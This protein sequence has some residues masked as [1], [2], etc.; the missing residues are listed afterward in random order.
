MAED[1]T[2][3]ARAPVEAFQGS[4]SAYFDDAE[5]YM[6]KQWEP[7]IWPMIRDFDFSVTLDFAAGHGRNSTR[8]AKL[9]RQLYIVDANADA[10]NFLRKRFADYDARQCSI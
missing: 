5:A 6:G 3:I 2:A 9:A 4:A 1:I 7:L 10:V 8:L